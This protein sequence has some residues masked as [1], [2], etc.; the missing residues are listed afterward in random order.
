MAVL[1]DASPKLCPESNAQYACGHNHA[2]AATWV[3]ES[4]NR[5]MTCRH[6]AMFSRPYRYTL[7]LS[8]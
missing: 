2:P 7:G 5:P 1:P 6:S 4:G 3:S 8:A